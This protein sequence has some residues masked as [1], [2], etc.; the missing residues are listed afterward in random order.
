MTIEKCS[1]GQTS[2][3]KAVELYTITNKNGMQVAVST[4][5]GAV[6]KILVPTENG[7]IDVV[8]GYD[9]VSGYEGQDTYIGSLIG[10]VGNRIEKGRFILE[11]KEYNLYL[12]NGRNH[13]H[14]GKVG[15][16]KKIWTVESA[17]N[18]KIRLSYV[19]ADKEEGYPG[20]LSIYVSYKLTECNTLILDYKA[21]TTK[22]TLCNPTNHSYFNLSGYDSGNVGEQTVQL[23]ADEYTAADKDSI[24]HGE[25]LPVKGTPFDLHEARPI[26]NGWDADFETI[27]EAGGYD[28]NFVVP[29][30]NGNLK[31]IARTHSNKTNISMTVYTT[32]PGFQFYTGNYL[33]PAVKG[34]KN[35]PMEKRSGYCFESQYF[36]N[37]VNIPS[38][39]T[40]VLR[41]GNIYKST[42]AYHFD[43]K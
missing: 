27:R 39:V 29:E 20:E 33:D 1:F 10:R 26:K 6:Q 13:L 34:K 41:A 21:H 32:L 11:G 24:P 8:L 31:K 30:Y 7:K 12:N 18:N 19:S 2:D 14:G 36:P 37:A 25:I 3:G 15:F 28:H 42:T 22:D 5:G 17:D 40:P 43:A 35:T 9:N 4:F 23:F 38:F 16:D